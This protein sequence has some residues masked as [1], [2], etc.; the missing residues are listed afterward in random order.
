MSRHRCVRGG[1]LIGVM[2]TMAGVEALGDATPSSDQVRVRFAT[3]N[4]WEL[5]SAKLGRVDAEGRGTT[6]QLRKAAEIIQRVRPD[7]LLV[8]EIDF[9]PAERKNAALFMERYLKVPQGG[10]PPID[11][12]HIFFAPVNTGVP[13][14][15][16]L[17]NDG[18][19]DGP[20]DAFG[21]GKYEGQYGMALYS[22][23]P[24]DRAQV[25]TFQKFKWM[26]MPGNLM[27]DGTGGKPKWYAPLEV[28][29][30][31]LSSKSHWDIPLEIAAGKTGGSAVVL[32]VLAAHPTP[33]AF[34]GAE[35][36]NGRRNFDEIRL[37]ADYLTG[38][39]RAA[40]LVDDR[41]Q[42]GGLAADTSFVIMGDLN[43]DPDKDE[44]PYGLAAIDQLLKLPRVQDPQ[45]RH[46]G[47]PNATA[48]ASTPTT[49]HSVLS[50]Q[51]SVLLKTADFGRID[52]V[53]PSA[54]LKVMDAGVFWPASGDPLYRLI[55]EPD[56]SSDHHLVWIDVAVMP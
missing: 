38:G 8:N 29:V 11:Y 6:P 46:G 14:G 55:A 36:R 16:D 3:F 51:S 25:R 48:D 49:Q 2:A 4:I 43:A 1:L 17:D 56:P 53:L 19:S 13:T 34:D 39:E 33:P 12:A 9:D 27:P 32:H 52:Y 10:Q 20:E 45:P 42:R 26:D 7:V 47:M 22:R 18:K 40:Y 21:Y 28:A 30:L 37:W 35:D 15:L 50:P 31:R 54:N 44:R 5:T 23:F 41:G 24:L